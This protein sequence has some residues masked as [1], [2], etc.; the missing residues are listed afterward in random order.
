MAVAGGLPHSAALRAAAEVIVTSNALEVRAFTGIPLIL[1]RAR[2]QF[3]SS[4]RAASHFRKFR[5]Q[6]VGHAAGVADRYV[7][8]RCG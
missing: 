5:S 6:R 2:A 4:M 1:S 3:G 7:N 8:H